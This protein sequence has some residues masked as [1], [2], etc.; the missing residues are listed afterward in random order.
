MAGQ[1]STEVSEQHCASMSRRYILTGAPGSGKTTLLRALVKRDW[2]GVAE[3]ATDVIADEQSTGCLEPWLSSDFTS[4]IVALQRQR[5]LANSRSCVQ[6]YDRSPVCT[7]ALARYLGQRVPSCLLSEVDRVVQDG[8]Y[9]NDVFL[10]RP[11]GFIERTAAR[12]ISY[13]AAVE[14]EAFHVTAY[15]EYGFALVDVPAMTVSARTAAVEAHVRLTP[16]RR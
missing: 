13:P 9:E 5:Q 8:V 3:A 1:R 10:V 11:L 15:Q 7:L 2:S 14:F 4:N 6:F 16:E 12:R